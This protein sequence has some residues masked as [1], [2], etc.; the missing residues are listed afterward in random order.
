MQLHEISDRLMQLLQ[1]NEKQGKELKESVENT[2]RKL[3]SQGIMNTVLL[4]L[5]FIAILFGVIFAGVAA[6]IFK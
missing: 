3:S 1:I 5:I 2:N 4:A 6:G